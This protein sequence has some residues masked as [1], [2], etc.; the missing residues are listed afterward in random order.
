[1][2]TLLIWL[3]GVLGAAVVT[4]LINDPLK[5]LLAR[6]IGGYDPRDTS[7]RGIWRATYDYPTEGVRKF[8]EHYFEIKQVL[9]YVVART[10]SPAPAYYRLRGKLDK[11]RFLTGRWEE[12][13]PDGR[14]YHGAFQ[15]AVRPQGKQMHG[16]W[17][18][19]NRHDVVMSGSWNWERESREVTEEILGR[20]AEHSGW[21]KS[22]AAN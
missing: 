5:F 18:G 17:V 11:D 8:E 13:T 15:L 19:F 14:Y 12:K 22:E 20:Y 4:V 6:V 1:M 10:I 3:L 2:T 7:L 21:D 9:P 16:K